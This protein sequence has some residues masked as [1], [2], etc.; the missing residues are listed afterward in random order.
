MVFVGDLYRVFWIIICVRLLPSKGLK[1]IGY[2][3]NL[4]TNKNKTQKMFCHCFYMFTVYVKLLGLDVS[5]Y[6]ESVTF[7]QYL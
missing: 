5:S 1:V 7:E 4:L 3:I 2:K 6:F